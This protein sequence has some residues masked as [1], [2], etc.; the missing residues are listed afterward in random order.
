MEES[1][2]L[3]N[4]LLYL[5]LHSP[6]PVTDSPKY[7]RQL[8]SKNYQIR[9]AAHKRLLKYPV[10]V[11]YYELRLNS[12]HCPPEQKR[13][14]KQ[15]VREI[16]NFETNEYISEVVN[17]DSKKMQHY[18]FNVRRGD[19]LTNYDLLQQY[20]YSRE[21]QMEAASLFYQ[22]CARLRIDF[23]RI[24]PKKANKKVDIEEKE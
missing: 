7:I 5:Y 10:D 3:L 16:M 9:D 21:F 2:V 19:S 24:L 22:D 17:H 13:R 6:L 18:I 14:L 20:F 23:T 11:N 4:L 12:P 1:Q 8:E 15:I